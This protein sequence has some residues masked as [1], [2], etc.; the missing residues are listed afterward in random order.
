MNI[1]IFGCSGSI[2][3]HLTK[4][5]LEQNKNNK[6]YGIDVKQSKIKL[7]NLFS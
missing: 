3:T 2:G 1:L 4:F 5:Y 7:K 6:V